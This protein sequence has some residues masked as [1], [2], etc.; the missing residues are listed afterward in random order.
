MNKI[1]SDNY[2]VKIKDLLVVSKE[3]DITLNVNQENS[4]YLHLNYIQRRITLNYKQDEGGRNELFDKISQ[5]I[6]RL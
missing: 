4:Y 2:I 6:A 3:D 5:K 1:V